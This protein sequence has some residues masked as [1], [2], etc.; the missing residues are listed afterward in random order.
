MNVEAKVQ[1]IKKPNNKKTKEVNKK[2]KRAN[3]VLTQKSDKRNIDVRKYD[4]INARRHC[5][6]SG[7]HLVR[8][9]SS[10]CILFRHFLVK[11]T[12]ININFIST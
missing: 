1:E 9:K 6:T 4:N 8:Y 3:Q 12:H 5:N 7:F 2:I 11:L 10:Y